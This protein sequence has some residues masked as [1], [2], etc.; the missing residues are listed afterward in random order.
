MRRPNVCF[1]GQCGIDLWAM[2][3]IGMPRLPFV[4][5][6][7]YPS[8]PEHAQ[9]TRELTMAVLLYLLVCLGFVSRSLHIN[10]KSQTPSLS[11]L[12]SRCWGGDSRP[13]ININELWDGDWLTP[14]PT[15][16]HHTWL[17]LMFI[18]R[19]E[20]KCRPRQRLRKQAE[21][22]LCYWTHMRFTWGLCLQFSD[23]WRW[24]WLV[25]YFPSVSSFSSLL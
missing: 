7:A 21:T 15:S 6:S 1:Q 20:R 11:G 9:K 18:H 10:P 5:L 14:P 22:G 23:G 2:G 8:L 13:I 17:P 4:P 16:P 19:S 3:M 12:K 25:G 24:R